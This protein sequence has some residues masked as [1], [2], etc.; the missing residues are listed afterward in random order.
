VLTAMLV[1]EPASQVYVVSWSGPTVVPTPAIQP[2]LQV[3][4][5]V[6]G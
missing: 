2:S 1:D 5:I 3:H 6:A 4:S